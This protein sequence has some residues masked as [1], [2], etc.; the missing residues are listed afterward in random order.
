MDLLEALRE[1]ATVRAAIVLSSD[2]VYARH[3][4]A[5]SEALPV[6]EGGITA[7]AKLVS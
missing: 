7:T 2:K 6:A 3:Q 1:T 4:G 5:I